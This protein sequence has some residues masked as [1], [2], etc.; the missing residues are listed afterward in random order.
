[1]NSI[2]TPPASTDTTALVPAR[3]LHSIKETEAILGISHATLYRLIAA[4]K[5]D[6]RKIGLKTVITRDSI[7]RLIAGLPPAPIRAAT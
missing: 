1:M 5:L 3:A 6:A 4:G 7:A 2:S